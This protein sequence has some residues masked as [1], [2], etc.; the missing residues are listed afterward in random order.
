VVERV[1]VNHDVTGSN[2]VLGADK[3]LKLEIV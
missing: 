3:K 1:A 2:P